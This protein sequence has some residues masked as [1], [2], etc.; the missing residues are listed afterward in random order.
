MAAA[1]FSQTV[2]RLSRDARCGSSPI[3]VADRDKDIGS[4]FAIDRAL[5]R[6]GAPEPIISQAMAPT[7]HAFASAIVEAG[8]SDRAAAG[9][10]RS[11][12]RTINPARRPPIRTRQQPFCFM[13]GYRA[14]PGKRARET[15]EMFLRKPG[16][17]H[18]G[19]HSR[20]R[21]QRNSIPDIGD[22]QAIL[23]VA[24]SR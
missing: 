10:R 22:F 18:E 15:V 16:P 13:F 9:F 21:F 7:W 12:P 20:G 14:R 6:I 4:V 5:A 19:H 8:A 1:E 23:P 11:R 2:L 17:E 24:T 3:P